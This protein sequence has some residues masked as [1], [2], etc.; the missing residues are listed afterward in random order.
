MKVCS[1]L[2]THLFYSTETEGE[3]DYQQQVE[4]QNIYIDGRKKILCATYPPQRCTTAG[5]VRVTVNER[6][7]P[8][9]ELCC[10]ARTVGEWFGRLGYGLEVELEFGHQGWEGR[11]GPAAREKQAQVP[12][13]AMRIF[14]HGLTLKAAEIAGSRWSFD[15][16]STAE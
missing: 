12:G 6:L 9:F 10:V 13:R 2:Y 8:M 7:E 1:S 16:R 4:R 14:A 15:R 5:S 3:R 11:P